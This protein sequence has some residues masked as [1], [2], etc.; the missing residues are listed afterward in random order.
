MCADSYGR[1]CPA[2]RAG[3][4]VRSA[5]RCRQFQEACVLLRRPPSHKRVT[6]LIHCPSGLQPVASLLHS[7]ESHIHI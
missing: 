5:P 7:V 2:Q 4:F 6:R 3:D 1:F